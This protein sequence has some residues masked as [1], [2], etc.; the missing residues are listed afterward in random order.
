MAV[1]THQIY[2]EQIAGFQNVHN[3]VA[4]VFID[5]MNV[6]L[7]VEHQAEGVAPILRHNQMAVFWKILNLSIG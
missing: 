2:A 4:V 6:D 5:E 3:A 1:C 7:A